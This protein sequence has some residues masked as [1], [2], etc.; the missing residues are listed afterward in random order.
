VFNRAAIEPRIERLAAYLG[1]PASFEAFMEWVLALRREIGVPHT[2]V[3][4]GVPLDQADLVAEMAL[5]DPTAGSNPMQLTK[6]SLRGIFERAASGEL[7]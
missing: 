4:F 1:L 3:A 5:H 6:E 7:A 2:L